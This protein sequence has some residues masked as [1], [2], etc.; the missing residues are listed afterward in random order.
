VWRLRLGKGC[1]DGHALYLFPHKAL[2]QDHLKKLEAFG[3]GLFGP[4]DLTAEIYDGDTPT[5]RRK[6][7]RGLSPRDG[8]VPAS[9]GFPRAEEARCTV[10]SSAWQAGC[11][12]MLV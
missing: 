10:Q 2:E 11:R 4:R 12:F 5:S 3:R 8:K 7:I 6:K 9:G 1:G